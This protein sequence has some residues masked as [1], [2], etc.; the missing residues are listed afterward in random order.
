MS[1]NDDSSTVLS[2]R[3]SEVSTQIL[4]NQTDKPIDVPDF[5]G[6]SPYTDSEIIS[7]DVGL[8]KTRYRIHR[9]ILAQSPEL[10]S[11]PSLKLWGEKTHDT[12]SLPDLD[13]VTAHTVLAFLYTG[14]YETLAWL[15]AADKA[16]IAA[17]KLSTCVYCAASRYKLPQLAEL[18]QEK[19]TGYGAEL[20]IL[21]IL[22]VAREHAF[23]IL[24]ED[25]TWFASYLE[26]A[27]KS[28]VK[29]DP[30]LFT[31]PGF[32]DQI[33]GDRKFRQ[34]VMTAIVN[35][36]SG[37]IGGGD[38]L[39]MDSH[40]EARSSVSDE[41]NDKSANTTSLAVEDSQG[42]TVQL[43]DIEPLVP[44]SPVHRPANPLSPK[45][46]ESVTD[47][48]DLKNRT[49]QSTLALRPKVDDVVIANGTAKRHVRNDSVVQADEVGDVDGQER[50]EES[51]ASPGVEIASPTSEAVDPVPVPV[52]SKNT[53]KNKKKKP[54]RTGFAGVPS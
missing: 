27:I 10:A 12:V 44:E 45:A 6:K 22:G 43:D 32:V 3:G 2:V 15:G 24:P 54:N 35:T 23:P 25:E 8:S 46:P 39:P 17:Y 14:R 51:V 37:G 33:E 34:V 53:K 50:E 1:V 47:E 18:A 28:A 7:L 26:G 5:Y 29:R 36:Y 42:D 9:S 20:T 4:D 13:A 40:E 52:V 16:S 31:K 11:K 19:I 30:A 38:D 21:D 41:A 49:F 48:L